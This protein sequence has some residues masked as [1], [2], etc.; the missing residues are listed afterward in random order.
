MH[1][2]E[3]GCYAHKAQAHG[4]AYE[5]LPFVCVEVVRQCGPVRF[6]EFD[7]GDTEVRR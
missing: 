1:G 2:R 6:Y 5:W 4:A 3:R 7:R